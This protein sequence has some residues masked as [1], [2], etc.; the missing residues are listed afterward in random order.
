MFKTRQTAIKIEEFLASNNLKQN[1]ATYYVM[2]YFDNN[3]FAGDYC[4]I[5][6]FM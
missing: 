2:I 6:M 5:F 3:V 1:M 4:R